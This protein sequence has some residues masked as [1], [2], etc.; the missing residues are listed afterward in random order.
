[1]ISR[2]CANY[3]ANLHTLRNISRVIKFMYLTCCQTNLV[4][5]GRITR[6]SS[7][8]QLTLGKFT[9][10]RLRNRNSRIACARHTHCL[11]DIATT[12]QRIANRTTN[13]GSCAAKGLNLGRMIVSFI[14]EQEQPILLFSVYIHLALYRACI[15][16]F[17]FIQILQTTMST[18]IL[19]ADGSHIHQAHRFMFAP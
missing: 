11:I 6:C 2:R 4:A 7:G 15:D 3:R 18:Q 9:F 16:F 10:E 14:L 17:G 8:Y 12:R 13:A 1:M 19:S 5:I